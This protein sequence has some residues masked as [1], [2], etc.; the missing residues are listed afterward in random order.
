MSII[1]LTVVLYEFVPWSGRDID[2]AYYSET[3][4][5]NLLSVGFLAL[6]LCVGLAAGFT[7]TP[8]TIG[9]VLTSLSSFL[10]WLFPYLYPQVYTM[11]QWLLIIPSLISIPLFIIGF[12]MSRNIDTLDMMF[13]GSSSVGIFGNSGSSS[14]STGGGT[15]ITFNFEKDLNQNLV[16][17]M[18]SF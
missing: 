5:W 10:K 15:S 7:P 16:A 4:F 3:N 14:G 12:T 2:P 8:P 11:G 6:Q 18:I 9:E 13:N 1:A 17:D